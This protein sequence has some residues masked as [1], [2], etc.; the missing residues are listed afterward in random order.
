MLGWGGPAPGGAGAAPG[1]AGAAPGG[2]GAAPGGAGAAGGTSSG[3]NWA[4]GLGIFI[5]P[6]EAAMV[7]GR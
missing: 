1:G 3:F 4:G 6:A 5:W 2:A 7:E